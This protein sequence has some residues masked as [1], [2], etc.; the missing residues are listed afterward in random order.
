MCSLI[1]NTKGSS[2]VFD[3]ESYRGINIVRR[4]SAPPSTPRLS[5]TPQISF[6][7]TNTSFCISI[8]NCSNYRLQGSLPDFSALD[9]F[10]LIDLS[11]NSLSGEIPSFLRNLPGL[12][13]LLPLMLSDK[14][15]R[16][17][18]LVECEGESIDMSGDVGAVGRVIISETQSKNHEM[19]LARF[20]RNH[21]QNN[22]TS[23]PNIL[24]C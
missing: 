20:K 5:L 19:L 9:T 24:H 3:G 8:R 7:S 6:L 21:I 1:E 2:Y 18:A 13:M 10:Q 16:S 14:V 17:K 23:M 4:Q 12:N 11:N 15:Q 22:H